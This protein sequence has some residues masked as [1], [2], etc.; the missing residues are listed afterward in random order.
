MKRNASLKKWKNEKQKTKTK[1]PPCD[2]MGA[3]HR[4]RNDTSKLKHVSI[5]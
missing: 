5:R 3:M 4:Y 2:A 1:T